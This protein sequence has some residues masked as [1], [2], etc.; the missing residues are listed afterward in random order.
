VPIYR[1]RTILL[2]VVAILA[3][4]V[5]A[6]ANHVF[7]DVSATHTHHDAIAELDRAGI[8]SG[9]APNEFCPGRA[10]TRAQ[11]A[12]FLR[13]GATRVS[14]DHSVTTL[15][16]GAGGLASGVPVTVEVGLAGASGGTTNLALQGN[17]TVMADA[18]AAD[19]P[20]EVEAFVY[21]ASDD[22]QGPSSW[23][24]LAEGRASV[25]VPV[26]WG[27]TVPSNARHEYRVAVFVDGVSDPA[28][29]RAEGTLTAVSG[30]FGDTAG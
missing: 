9:C 19:C 23:S 25:A 21:R 8:T 28:P 16:L 24:T 5:P 15:A 27:L 30:P 1:R 10:V 7:R 22:A 29:Y 12:T 20:C 26:S 3:L 13:R 6:A 14:S 2:V 11:M 17:V 18:G 4:A